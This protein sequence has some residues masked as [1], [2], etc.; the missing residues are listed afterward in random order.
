MS[1]GTGVRG[2]TG[3][4]AVV[5]P[6][7]LGEAV[8]IAAYAT[9]ATYAAYAAYAGQAAAPTATEMA[10]EAK[11]PGLRVTAENQPRDDGRACNQLIRFHVRI[12]R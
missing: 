5:D 12:S 2:S 3:R 8:G 9:C 6:T 7:G 4:I 11:T 1:P 10:A